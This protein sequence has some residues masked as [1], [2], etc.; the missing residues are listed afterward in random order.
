MFQCI[1]LFQNGQSLLLLWHNNKL[2]HPPELQDFVLL[3]KFLWGRTPRPP[4]KQNC[5]SLYCNHNTANH[6]NK[7]KNTYQN[8][9]P[10]PHHFSGDLKI[11][12]S[13]YVLFEK[14]IVDH[15]LANGCL[16]EQRKVL[17]KSLKMYLKSPWKVLE[18]GMSWSV[19]TMLSVIVRKLMSSL[20]F[21]TFT[22]RYTKGY[23]GRGLLIV[24][25]KAYFLIL[26]FPT[27]RSTVNSC[28]WNGIRYS[29]F[30]KI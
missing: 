30:H 6:L 17:E 7:N 18:K 15:F 28:V 19:G 20:D 11:K 24:W 25:L 27:P 22:V 1:N 16:K 29:T 13:L 26:W 5:L 10:P 12:W 3:I 23:D 14:S 2:V 21:A 9:P 4:F 8:L